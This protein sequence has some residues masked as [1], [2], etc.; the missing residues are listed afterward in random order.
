MYIGGRREGRGRR[1]QL[2][3][4]YFQHDVWRRNVR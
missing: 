1:I 4:G 2:P 3:H